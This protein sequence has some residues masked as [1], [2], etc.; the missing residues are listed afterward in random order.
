MLETVII[1]NGTNFLL[2][3]SLPQQ[4]V[5]K[6]IKVLMYSVDEIIETINVEKPKKVSQ[7]RGIFT[8]EEG[9]KFHHYLNDSRSE[10]E[11]NI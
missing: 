3:L 7:F 2:S 11:R 8:K 9:Q 6:K 5:G 4:F 10:W 1:P